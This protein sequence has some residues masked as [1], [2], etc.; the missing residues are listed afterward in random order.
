MQKKADT[1]SSSCQNIINGLSKVSINKVGRVEVHTLCGHQ[2]TFMG[3]ISTWSL[4]RFY[5]EFSLIIHSDGT[6]TEDDKSKWET[7]INPITFIEPVEGLQIVES[8]IHSLKNVI[9]L[10][11]ENI[12]GKKCVDFQITG[13]HKKML[14]FDTDILFFKRSESIENEFNNENF[15]FWGNDL[16]TFY[17]AD[18]QWINDVFGYDIPAGVCT[19]LLG[20]NKI[21]DEELEQI[22]RVLYNLSKNGY[23]LS[24]YR[25]EQLLYA[26]IAAMRRVRNKLGD[27][28]KVVYGRT[29]KNA[30]YRHYV[31]MKKI[32]PRYFTEGIEMLLNE[33]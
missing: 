16:G 31:G 21:N 20:M 27:E 15:M 11:N 29:K 10:R 19:G 12:Y 13:N 2:Q 30:T 1:I 5:K 26:N 23:E 25:L 3:I 33:F 28:L 17:G 6:L 24:N 8:K 32:R 4:L 14:M 7:V 18:L 9:K 22:D